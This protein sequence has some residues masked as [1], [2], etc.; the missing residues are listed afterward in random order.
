MIDENFLVDSA[1]YGLAAAIKY[2]QRFWASFWEA[3]WSI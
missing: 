1:A 3:M 2:P